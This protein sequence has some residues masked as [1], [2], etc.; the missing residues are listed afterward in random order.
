LPAPTLALEAV[1]PLVKSSLP[2][3]KL[4]VWLFLRS[5][6][7]KFRI[8]AFLNLMVLRVCKIC[9]RIPRLKYQLQYFY[10]LL[11]HSFSYH[12]LRLHT[13]VALYLQEPSTTYPYKFLCRILRE[14]FVLYISLELTIKRDF[15]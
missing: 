6:I 1:V 14:F 11:S 9:S 8:T 5:V 15:R 12:F 4:F 2:F 10:I 7:V 13:I 3:L